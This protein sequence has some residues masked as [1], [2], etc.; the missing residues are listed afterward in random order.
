MGCLIL[1]TSPNG[2]SDIS[3]YVTTLENP[4]NKDAISILGIYFS[5]ENSPGPLSSPSASVS[6]PSSSGKSN[7]LSI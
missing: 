7:S 5:S 1:M 4:F 2:E 6:S 3:L